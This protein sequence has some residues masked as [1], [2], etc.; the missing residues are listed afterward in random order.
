MNKKD[1]ILLLIETIT[2]YRF[3]G[4]CSAASHLYHSGKIDVNGYVYL[5]WLIKTAKPNIFER[6]YYCKDGVF[7][8]YSIDFAYFWT[9]GIK[10]PRIKWLNKQLD[11]LDYKKIK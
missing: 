6:R 3:T 7:R 11:K 8:P 2:K 5:K 1:L 4:M 10:E 9:P